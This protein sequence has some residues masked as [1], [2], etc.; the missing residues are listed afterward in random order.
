MSSRRVIA[1][2]ALAC[3]ES[4]A[5]AERGKKT[6]RPENA[7]GVSTTQSGLRVGVSVANHHS[8]CT[9]RPGSSA[10]RGTLRPWWSAR[11]SARPASIASNALLPVLRGS[12]LSISRRTQSS[13]FSKS[14]QNCLTPRTASGQVVNAHSL[15]LVV[16]CKGV[17][18]TIVLT[19]RPEVASALSLCY[20]KGLAPSAAKIGACDAV[21][22][23]T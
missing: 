1:P 12:V 3:A 15:T 19:M 20:I 13:A 21:E 10:Q 2:F 5:S 4:P 16:Q 9:D 7:A 23:W 11:C 18:P 8:S 22:R 14:I 6:P 17:A